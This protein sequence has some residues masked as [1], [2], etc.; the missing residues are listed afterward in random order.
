MLKTLYD[1]KIFKRN[2]KFLNCKRKKCEKYVEFCMCREREK[3]FLSSRD[4]K[5]DINAENN[6]Q[7]IL[8]QITL[9]YAV[10]RIDFISHSS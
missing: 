7:N 1:L 4:E 9:Y 10:L 8:I 6:F 2:E 5:N 3:S